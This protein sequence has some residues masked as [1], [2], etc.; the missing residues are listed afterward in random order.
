M[1]GVCEGH[2]FKNPET[3]SSDFSCDGAARDLAVILD[4]CR[5]SCALCRALN[6]WTIDVIGGEDLVKHVKSRRISNF[7]QSEGEYL[8]LNFTWPFRQ[9]A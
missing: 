7:L 1:L 4:S 5:I 8:K 2:V 9:Q 3:H 6:Y